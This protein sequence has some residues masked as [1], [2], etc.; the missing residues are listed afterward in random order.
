MDLA[1]AAALGARSALALGALIVVARTVI[2]AVRTFVLPRA[3][4]VPLSRAVFLAIRWPYDLLARRKADHRD[5]DRIMAS[6]APTALLALPVVWLGI[7]FV[8]YAAIFYALDPAIG[9][10]R[11]V[12]TSGSSLLTL[13]LTP[14]TRFVGH[15]AAYTEA[16]L[17]LALLALLITYLPSIYSAFQRREALVTALEVRA[18]VPPSP[19]TMLRRFHAIGGLD[20]LDGL[21]TDWQVWFVDVQESHTSLAALSFFRS[22]QPDLSWV[23][24]A[25]TVLDAAALS[26]SL[27]DRGRREPD[28][29]LCLRA[30][31]LCLRAVADSL[32]VEHDPDP[33]PDDPITITRAEFDAVCEELGALGLPLHEDIDAAWAAFAGWRVNYDRTLLGLA[34]LT[35]APPAMWS[36]DRSPPFSPRLRRPGARRRRP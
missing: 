11:A 2:S 26:T 18:G 7:V 36:S 22:P 8:A 23:T 13:G 10:E 32:R 21:W 3:A 14:P 1:A 9:L 24:A 4:A 15:L 28:A 35:M 20:R 34:S 27:I 5:V 31:F 19:V 6:Y 16:G 17:G 29:D 25:G 30:G 12:Q 33:Q